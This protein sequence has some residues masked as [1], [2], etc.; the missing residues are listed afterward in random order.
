MND[1]SK[2]HAC[3]TQAKV[4]IDEEESAR[5]L[6]FQA[7]VFRF[8]KCETLNWTPKEVETRITN[9]K[10]NKSDI[11]EEYYYLYLLYTH[12]KDYGITLKTDTFLADMLKLK[13]ATWLDNF[14]TRSLSIIELDHNGDVLPNRGLTAE[15]LMLLEMLS[16]I[17][18]AET[19]KQEVSTRLYT[20]LYQ[21]QQD[22]IFKDTDSNPSFYLS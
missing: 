21:F 5:V 6:Y 15:G 18:K 9:V 3:K 11:L 8:F 2:V 4:S 19:Q 13:V 12:L 16:A 17:M 14:D 22:G 7:E 10:T 20:I 1:Y